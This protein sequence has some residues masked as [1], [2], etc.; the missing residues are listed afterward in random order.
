MNRRNFLQTTFGIGIATASGGILTACQAITADYG[1][2]LAANADGLMLPAGFTSRIVATTGVAVTGTA[3]TW[4]GAPDG[5]AVF[6]TA[7][8]GWIYTS[9]SEVSG[10]GGGCGAIEFDSVGAIIGARSILSGTSSNCAGGPTPWGTW[11]S[12][13]ETD[14]GQ[15]WECDPTG[16]TGALARPALGVFKHEAAAVDPVNEHIYLTEDKSNGGLYRFVPTAYPSL[17]AGTLEV[18][19][20]VSGTLGW[21]T[22]PDPDGSPTAT[23]SQVPT[24]KQFNGGEGC[25]Y[26][27]GVLVFTTKGDNRVW[28]YNIAANT[29]TIMYDDNTS[30]TPVLTGVDNV[31]ISP[32]TPH[33]FV[34]EDG[35]NMEIV[36]VDVSGQTAY[37]FVRITG[38]AGSE[39]TGPAFT[40][41]GSRMYFSSQRTPGETF[42][43]TGPFK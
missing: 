10:G 16:A 4:H 5:G 25:W 29:L 21:A 33:I 26:R 18:L 2:L 11:L 36:A 41:D 7:G 39:V 3:Y 15:V 43:V 6:P 30:P 38:R 24:M 17:T 35:G 28:G 31:T 1:A 19:T 27:L 40:A 23:R 37:P 8:G 20:E 34:A 14:T 42:E 13:E 32:K 22:V 9:N 12:C